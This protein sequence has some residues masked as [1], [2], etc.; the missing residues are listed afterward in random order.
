MG[1]R[2]AAELAARGESV[3]IL[4]LPGDPVAAELGEKPFEVVYGDI[5]RKPELNAALRGMDIVFHLAAVLLSPGHEEVFEAVNAE[6]TRN[7]VAAAEAEGVSHFIYVSSISVMYPKSNAYARSKLR[8]EEWV[9]SSRLKNFTIVRPS[10]AYQDG[11]AEEFMRFVDHLRRGSVVPLPGGGRARKSPVH[12]EDLVSA[13]LAL[14]G[15]H[16][17]YGKTYLLTG[18][19]TLSLRRMAE[20]LLI[21]MGR[22][23]PI[24]G[25]PK[26]ICLMGVA[27]LALWSKVSGS[28][29]PFT[30]QTYTG[31]IQDAAP[32]DVGARMDLDYNPRKF[33]DG[34]ATL[35]SLRDCL[36][37]P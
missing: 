25:V 28:K 20:V 2:L 34:L 35:V 12:I 1:R 27:G 4:C 18:G 19:E 33:H 32:Q 9:K 29:N 23:K 5:T 13:F 15:N 37:T 22:P 11:G 10:L 21:H 30:L 24:V 7:L 17:A 3:R 26:W 8:G 31:L 36:R 6:G 16:K 14:P